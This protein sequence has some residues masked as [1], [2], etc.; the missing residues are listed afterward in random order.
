VVTPRT[1]RGA[2]ALAA[3]LLAGC[4]TNFAPQYLVSD[5]RILAIRGEV[6]G[7]D[8]AADADTGETV[9]LTALVGNP[10]G[11]PVTV[12]WKACLPQEGQA[13]S[14]CLDAAALR[15]PD[16]ISGPGVVDLG[17]GTSLQIQVPDALAPA[18]QQV[19]ARAR[20]QPSLACTLYVELPVLVVASAPGAQT[21]VAVKTVRLTPWREVASDPRL[22]GVYVR[23]VNPALVRVRTGADEAACRSGP[24][25][26]RPCE[27]SDDCPAGAG[28]SRVACRLGPPGS[29]RAAGQCEDPLPA[30][31]Q[32]L[33]AADRDKVVADPV[34]NQCLEDGTP[35]PFFEDVTLQ[36]YATGGT[37]KGASGSSPG[38]NGNVV[39]DVV[40]FTP[41]SGPFTLWVVVR[42][43]RGGEDWLQRDFP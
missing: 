40:T 30:G 37:F 25:V 5:L 41:P 14:P 35:Q 31:E 34:Y 22:G 7:A 20:A 23:N 15:D 11:L 26:A 27:T 33:C 38:S 36:W 6:L 19:I 24:A 1:L 13:V 17:A 42:D 43:G 16:A 10:A 12:R 8:D 21:R 2:A 18:L 39:D 29:A 3:L 9:R 4:N 28:Q 32:R